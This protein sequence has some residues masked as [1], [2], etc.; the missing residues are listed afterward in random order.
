MLPHFE[1][2]KSEDQVIA[3]IQCNILADISFVGITLPLD[4]QTQMEYWAR[5]APS[6]LPRQAFKEN[7]DVVLFSGIDSSGLRAQ[8]ATRN[9]IRA[10]ILSVVFHFGTPPFQ[11]SAITHVGGQS[12]VE[13]TQ[14]LANYVPCDQERGEVLPKFRYE[15]VTWTRESYSP[16]RVTPASHNV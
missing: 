2:Y 13:A 12:F 16:A 4:A 14:Y 8:L 1:F 9:E 7:Y 11:I 6:Y 15:P 10:S 5:Q 3:A